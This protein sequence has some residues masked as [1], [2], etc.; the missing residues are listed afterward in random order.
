MIENV[1]NNWQKF[2]N[3]APEKT[4]EDDSCLGIL[5]RNPPPLRKA[6]AQAADETSAQIDAALGPQLEDELARESENAVPEAAR[7]DFKRFEEFCT[8]L[9]LSPTSPQAVTGFL[10]DEGHLGAKHLRKLGRNISAVHQCKV[11]AILRSIG[12]DDLIDPTS[13]VLVRA[14]L[15]Q[16]PTW[17]KTKQ[18]PNGKGH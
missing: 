3:M 12:F 15:R 11:A 1:L 17:P 4:E 7:R 16:A 9:G 8:G 6:T 5:S 13:D 10:I 2:G 14:L 18:P